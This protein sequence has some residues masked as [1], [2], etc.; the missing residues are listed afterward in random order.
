MKLGSSEPK[1]QT[2]APVV[3]PNTRN[4]WEDRLQTI[5]F[6]AGHLLQTKVGATTITSRIATWMSLDQQLGRLPGRV[7]FCL[8]FSVLM[9]PAIHSN[10][11]P[12]AQVFHVLVVVGVSVSRFK[13]HHFR[14]AVPIP[15]DCAEDI[16]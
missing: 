2:I 3:A 12:D 15:V 9:F 13:D 1:D 11:R 7:D 6:D 8:I 10:I 14:R 16:F 5:Q 4:D